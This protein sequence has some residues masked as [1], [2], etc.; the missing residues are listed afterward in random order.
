MSGNS[1]ASA[2]GLVGKTAA[3]EVPLPVFGQ[4]SVHPDGTT[5]PV[6]TQ[7]GTTPPLQETAVG[8]PGSPIVLPPARPAA[9]TLPGTVADNEDPLANNPILSEHQSMRAEVI[10]PQDVTASQIEPTVDEATAPAPEVD[11]EAASGGAL[12]AIVRALTAQL[13]P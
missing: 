4:P 7:P 3:N 6:T 2:A 10:E 13:R 1:P 11:D 12:S 5:P 9:A 8:T